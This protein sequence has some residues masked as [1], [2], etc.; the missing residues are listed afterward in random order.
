MSHLV[1][2]KPT[3]VRGYVTTGTDF[4]TIDQNTYLAINGDEGG[5]WSPSAPIVIGGAGFVF[6]G[7]SRLEGSADIV[8]TAAHNITFGQGSASDYFGLESNHLENVRE[9]NNVFIEAFS[10]DPA[11]DFVILTDEGGVR[12]KALGVHFV[13]PLKVYNGSTIDHAEFV[14]AVGEIHSGVPQHLSRFRIYAVDAFGVILPLK[15]AGVNVTDGFE[16]V[17]L[18]SSGAE[19]TKFG[20]PHRH[21][22]TCDVSHTVDV[23]KYSYFAEIIEEAGT[24]AW[25]TTG[26][27]Y[28]SAN[29]TCKNIALLDGRN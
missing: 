16:E 28:F 24:N 22:Y 18:P 15:S 9:L 5:T 2:A 3:W 29:L 21:V 4:Q 23:S 1:K 25:A 19:W 17:T 12:A 7:P 26:N 6:A 8:A 14:F 10:Y 13:V 27:V 11:N 20:A